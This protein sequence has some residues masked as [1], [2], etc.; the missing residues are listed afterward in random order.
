MSMKEEASVIA[1]TL[2]SIVSVGDMTNSVGGTSDGK[3]SSMLFA[4]SLIGV[5]AA[6]IFTY[7]N[8]VAEDDNITDYEEVLYI[9]LALLILSTFFWVIYI[10]LSYVR[11]NMIIQHVDTGKNRTTSLICGFLWIF[12]LGVMLYQCLNIIINFTCSENFNGKPRIRYQQSGLN[13]IVHFVSVCIQLIAIT[14]LS[15]CILKRNMFVNY[16]LSLIL[17]TNVAMWFFTSSRILFDRIN[18]NVINETGEIPE[19]QCY[20]NSTIQT[21]ILQKSHSVFTSLM[22]NSSL[23]TVC[24]VADMLP[25]ICDSRISYDPAS[26][27]GSGETP[28]GTGFRSIYSSITYHW[29]SLRRLFRRDLKFPVLAMMTLLPCLIVFICSLFQN[30][31]TNYTMIICW[32]FFST[33]SACAM[34]LTTLFG[35]SITRQY[36]FTTGAVNHNG[37]LRKPNLSILF[38]LGDISYCVLIIMSTGNHVFSYLFLL[39]Y[40]IEIT[41]VF[42]QTIFMIYLTKLQKIDPSLIKGLSIFLTLGNFLFWIFSEYSRHLNDPTKYFG[43]QWFSFRDAFFPVLSFYRLYSFMNFSRYALL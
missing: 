35:F 21:K 18:K 9:L 30:I 20:W 27:G 14:R 29:I 13:R 8:S 2:E 22:T 12:G 19:I 3:V 24:V 37:L 28:S 11:P 7:E 4:T 25:E 32:M 43:T 15:K 23:L 26:S 39:R 31:F 5:M 6:C 16:S 17:L 33:L 41:Q 36:S 34:A 42:L 10:T 1:R 40:S 38:S